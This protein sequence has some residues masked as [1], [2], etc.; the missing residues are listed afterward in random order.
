MVAIV[1]AMPEVKPNTTGNGIYS[2]NLPN[3]INPINTRNMPDSNVAISNPD[4]PYCNDTG[5]KIT[6]KAAVGPETLNFEPPVNAIMK[7]DIIAVY[8]PCC[9]GTP[10]AIANAIAN[11]IAIIPTVMP[12]IKSLRKRDVL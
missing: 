9:G 1:M 2:I 5:Y 10:L 7:P 8:R 6:T 4:N 11:G 12:A 3:R